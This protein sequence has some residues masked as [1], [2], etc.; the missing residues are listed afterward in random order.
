MQSKASI[1][2]GA[3]LGEFKEYCKRN[4]IHNKY[5]RLKVGLDVDVPLKKELNV[6]LDEGAWVIV[7]FKYEKLGVFCHLCGIIGHTDKTYLKRFET[8]TDDGIRGRSNDIKVDQRRGNLVTKNKWTL[9]PKV[10][11]QVPEM[12]AGGGQNSASNQGGINVSAT[13]AK[14]ANVHINVVANSVQNNNAGFMTVSPNV[15]AV[16]MTIQGN[17]SNSD[18]A[19]TLLSEDVLML[20]N[21]VE[22]EKKRT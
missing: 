8:E 5:I 12:A 16:N 7:L 18:V 14:M 9:D 13:N 11:V 4:S 20:T 3:Y 15:N 22:S 2:F 21:V 10:V 17:S 19:H 1:G 6:R